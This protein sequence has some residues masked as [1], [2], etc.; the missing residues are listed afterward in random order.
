KLIG[1]FRVRVEDYL[2]VPA[3]SVKD[4]RLQYLLFRNEFA[5]LVKTAKEISQLYSVLHGETKK[6]P[7][8][9]N[10]LRPS[11]PYSTVVHYSGV[12]QQRALPRAREALRGLQEDLF[13]HSDYA[14]ESRT[15]KYLLVTTLFVGLSFIVSL[16]N[17][18]VDS[19]RPAQTDILP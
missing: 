5:G 10:I 1:D 19:N 2:S 13:R 6:R 11:D 4:E 8:F 7:S 15:V 9:V 18:W 14:H 17:L 12:L 16:L 3:I